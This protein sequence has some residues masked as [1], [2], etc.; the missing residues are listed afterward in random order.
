MR[1][2]SE[3]PRGPVSRCLSRGGV[4]D[5]ARSNPPRP[6]PSVCV[7]GAYEVWLARGGRPSSAQSEPHAEG[8]AWVHQM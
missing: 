8:E 1:R 2:A 4:H 7:L 6:L 3:P 5:H